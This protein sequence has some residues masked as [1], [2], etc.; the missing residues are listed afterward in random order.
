MFDSIIVPAFLTRDQTLFSFWRRKT[1]CIEAAKIGPDLRF[2]PFGSTGYLT[3]IG[4]G[5]AKYRDLSVAFR[6]VIGSVRQIIDLRDKPVVA[7]PNVGCLL[8]LIDLM[9]WKMNTTEQGQFTKSKVL[10]ENFLLNMS[11]LCICQWQSKLILEYAFYIQLSLC[12]VYFKNIRIIY[13]W[14]I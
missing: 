4:R 11:L 10:S 6:S 2:R 1:E 14:D 8:R 9:K 13:W 12:S 3:I 5:W 7:S